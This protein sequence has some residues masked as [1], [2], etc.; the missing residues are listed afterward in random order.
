MLPGL[1]L[2]FPFSI[3]AQPTD[4]E[5]KTLF[6]PCPRSLRKRKAPINPWQYQHDFV[7]LG[8][9]HVPQGLSTFYK[10]SEC[11]DGSIDIEYTVK[12]RMR[13]LSSTTW[14]IDDDG[15]LTLQ[16]RDSRLMPRPRFPSYRHG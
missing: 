5:S 10:K 3:F 9:S 13:S 11:L 1:L 6:I 7:L 15:L 16:R 12:Q 2:I 4:P 8:L 14:R